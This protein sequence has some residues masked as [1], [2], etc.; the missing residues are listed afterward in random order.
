[1]IE[2]FIGLGSNLNDPTHQ[3]SRAIQRVSDIEKLTLM[4][5]SSLY[6]SA[7][8]GPQDQDPYVNAVIRVNTGLNP[9]AL[10]GSLAAIEE[11]FGRDRSVGHW[12]PRVIDLDILLYAQQEIRLRRLIVPHPGLTEREFVVYPLLEIAPN[13]TLP[14]GARLTE[15]AAKTIPLTLQKL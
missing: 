9:L 8:M 7:P 4:Q 12:G 14:G 3:I 5:Q 1:M 10:L 15:V 6:K 13:L 2:S 11:E